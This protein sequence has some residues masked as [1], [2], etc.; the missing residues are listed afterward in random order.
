[1]K[2][3]GLFFVIL[4]LLVGCSTEEYPGDYQLVCE[5]NRVESYNKDAFHDSFEK[6]WIQ[7]S[8][9]YS[10]DNYI[11]KS[12]NRVE[13]ILTKSVL[14]YLNVRLNGDKEALLEEFSKGFMY[15]DFQFI[16]DTD[17]VEVKYLEDRIVVNISDISPTKEEGWKGLI[18]P[19][20]YKF[21][22]LVEKMF[23]YEEYCELIED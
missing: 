16:Q 11:L 21:S 8:A 7:Y 10:Q 20:D 1:M 14:E 23:E 13:F 3:T 19:E 6:K 18:I 17:D 15:N 4:M 22:L 2:K 9:I 5:S 12:E